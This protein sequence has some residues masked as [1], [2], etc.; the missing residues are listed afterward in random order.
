MNERRSWLMES[1]EVEVGAEADGFDLV[2]VELAVGR[3]AQEVLEQELHLA[4]GQ[5][6][7]DLH[8]GPE[9]EIAAPVVLLP[10]LHAH[11]GNRPPAGAAIGPGARH[12]GAVL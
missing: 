11:G 8:A 7:V 3:A 4:G 5:H 6:A 9:R 1:S 2:L 12:L 10:V